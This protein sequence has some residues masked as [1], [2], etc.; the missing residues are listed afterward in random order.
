MLFL[1]NCAIP[2]AEHQALL[3]AHNRQFA[4]F[5]QPAYCVLRQTEKLG[6]L[7][8]SEELVIAFGVVHADS[9]FQ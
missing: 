4:L 7:A 8:Y 1:I 2:F 6:G 9:C 3:N 5:D